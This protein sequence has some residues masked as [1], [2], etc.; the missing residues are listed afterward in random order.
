MWTCTKFNTFWMSLYIRCSWNIVESGAKHYKLY[1][2]ELQHQ[3]S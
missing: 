2:L 1:Q 3:Q